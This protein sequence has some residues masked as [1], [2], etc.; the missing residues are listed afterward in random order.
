LHAKTCVRYNWGVHGRGIYLQ[1]ISRRV[2]AAAFLVF[3]LAEWGS[4][5]MVHIN[6]SGSGA[7]VATS[8][9]HR[10][11][12]CDTHIQC[13]SRRH[14]RQLP[15]ISHDLMPIVSLSDAFAYVMPLLGADEARPLPDYMAAASIRPP[16]PHFRPPEFA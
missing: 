16:D 10:D 4:H 13:D 6:S 2:V 3:M 14:D 8:G 15:G 12:P 1:K 7:V 11:D 5:V 9:S